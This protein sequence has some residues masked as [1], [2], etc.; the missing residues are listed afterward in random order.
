MTPRDALNVISEIDR[1]GNGEQFDVNRD[2]QITAKD[3]LLVI[4]RLADD[5]VVAQA[6]LTDAEDEDEI[7]SAS[8]NY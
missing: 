8:T 6:A 5:V 1:G 4:N 3:A 7:H 2:G